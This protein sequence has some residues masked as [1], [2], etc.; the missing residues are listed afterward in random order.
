MTVCIA[1]LS[2]NGKNAVL[3]TDKMLT[4]PGL[5]YQV[6]KPSYKKDYKVGDCYVLISGDTA[7]A[8]EVVSLAK[9]KFDKQNKNS[10]ES[11]VNTKELIR[12]AYQEFRR[13]VVIQRFIETRGLDLSSYYSGRIILPPQVIMEIENNLQNYNI[14][15]EMILVSKNSSNLYSLSYL[16]HPGELKCVDPIGYISIGCGSIHSLYYLTGSNYSIDK[17]I[18]EVEKILKKAKQ[19]AEK[20]PGVGKDTTI[21][22]LEQEEN[23]NAKYEK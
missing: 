7:N 15:L 20:S 21:I 9:E 23:Q 12:Q 18:K 11:N 1:A 10:P 17:S 19:Q 3:I 14:N 6:E 13:K 5:S 16:T 2:D 8:Y 22:K 4:L